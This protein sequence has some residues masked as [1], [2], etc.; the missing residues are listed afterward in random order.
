MCV[1]PSKSLNSGT[2]AAGSGWYRNTELKNTSG[3]IEY[4]SSCQ[5]I[6]QKRS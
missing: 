5:Q 4:F 1:A 2:D 6:Q 3:D